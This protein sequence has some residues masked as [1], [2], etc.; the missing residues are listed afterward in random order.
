VNCN[1]TLIQETPILQLDWIGNSVSLV[2]WH[3]LQNCEKW[4]S[5]SSCLSIHPS[6]HQSAWNNSASTGRIFKK[7][8]IWRF[9]KYLLRKFNFH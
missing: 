4:L 9:F 1:K 8:Y 5:A 2:F 7:F 6:V 3:V